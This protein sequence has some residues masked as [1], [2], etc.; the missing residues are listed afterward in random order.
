MAWVEDTEN[1][2]SLVSESAELF[3]DENEVALIM[4]CEAMLFI[5]DMGK[6]WAERHPYCECGK[7]Q[8]ITLAVRQYLNRKQEA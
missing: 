7:L 6:E 8:E 5:L 3:G 1:I 2:P 4:S